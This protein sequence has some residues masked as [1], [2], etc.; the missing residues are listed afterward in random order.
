MIKLTIT[1]VGNTRQEALGLALRAA[2]HMVEQPESKA[3]RI[4]LG[5][6]L[7]APTAWVDYSV[8]K[9]KPRKKANQGPIAVA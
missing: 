7:S 1:A 2:T 4:Q 3:Q 9:T 5:V 8:K 6:F